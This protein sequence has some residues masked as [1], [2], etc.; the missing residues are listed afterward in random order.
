MKPRLI[1]AAVTTVRV[2]KMVFFKKSWLVVCWGWP[3]EAQE[4]VEEEE[5]LVF[6]DDAGCLD[7]IFFFFCFEFPIPQPALCLSHL[8]KVPSIPEQNASSSVAAAADAA[9]VVFV[10]ELRAR[11]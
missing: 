1:E 3:K 7:Q 9:D 2:R 11:G 5:A 8:V 10:I 4:L 6:Q